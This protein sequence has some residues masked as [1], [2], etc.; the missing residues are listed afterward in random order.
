MPE[1]QTM[2]IP[3]VVPMRPALA[4]VVKDVKDVLATMHPGRSRQ[5]VVRITGTPSN[6]LVPEGTAADYGFDIQYTFIQTRKAK[7][8]DGVEDKDGDEAEDGAG[9]GPDVLGSAKA[10][11]KKK[12]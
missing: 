2:E 10:G 9:P 5:V 6:R 7:K 8:A 3:P 4:K 1:Q 12:A 11:G